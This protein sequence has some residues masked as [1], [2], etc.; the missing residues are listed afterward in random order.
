MSIT[1]IKQLEVS[2]IFDIQIEKLVRYSIFEIQIEKLVRYSIFEIQI[3]KLVRYS[4]FEILQ[5]VTV[6]CYCAQNP[7]LPSRNLP[8]TMFSMSKLTFNARF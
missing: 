5:T 4:I 7:S 1:T 3:E 2:S 8:H 6:S